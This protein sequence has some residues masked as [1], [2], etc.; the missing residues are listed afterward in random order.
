M[1]TCPNCRTALVRRP[2]S[3]GVYWSCGQCGGRAVGIAVLRRTI[4]ERIVTA[5][6]A[7]AMNTSAPN[8]R[9]CP[10]CARGMKEVQV[11]VAGN[12]MALDVCQRCEFMWFDADE[13]EAMPPPRPKPHVLGD[14]D[15]SKLPLA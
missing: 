13:F 9:A 7:A 14:V 5:A 12:A 3:L 1:F 8:G 6:G 4:H 11:D 15:E 10:V 2:G